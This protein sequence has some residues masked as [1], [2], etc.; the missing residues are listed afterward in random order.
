LYDT[1]WPSGENL[2]LARKE[3]A[4]HQESGL[5]VVEQRKH[6]DLAGGNKVTYAE[7]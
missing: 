4:L 1:Q 6:P 7:Q 3:R 5:A 2:A